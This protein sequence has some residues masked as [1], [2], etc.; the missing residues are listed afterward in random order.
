MR[1]SVPQENTDPIQNHP[2]ERTVT[3][4]WQPQGNGPHAERI[5]CR[6]DMT[7]LRGCPASESTAVDLER[8]TRRA[9]SRITMTKQLLQS[10]K[11]DASQAKW[12][13]AVID[14]LPD[15]DLA[16][17]AAELLKQIKK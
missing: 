13:Q 6:C 12:M 9:E 17:Q 2:T 11:A 5:T 16:K 1:D 10:R 7:C 4:C 14:E 15:T 8:A 3:G